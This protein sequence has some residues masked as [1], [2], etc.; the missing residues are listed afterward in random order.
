MTKGHPK[1]RKDKKNP[2]SE[3]LLNILKTDRTIVEKSFSNMENTIFSSVY[4][5]LKELK[6]FSKM[7]YSTRWNFYLS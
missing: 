7:G 1:Y 6:N 5:K 4:Y 2:E 3:N